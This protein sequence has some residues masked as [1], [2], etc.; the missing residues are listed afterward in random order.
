MKIYKLF[1]S[2]KKTKFDK[3]R[4]QNESM[5]S[6]YFGLVR[7]KA[8]EEL[9]MRLWKDMRNINMIKIILSS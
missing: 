2:K 7:S 9:N 3:N 8:I 4:I 6:E 1:I 5:I